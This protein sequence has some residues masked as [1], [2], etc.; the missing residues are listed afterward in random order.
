M[1]E[2]GRKLREL[3]MLCESFPSLLSKADCFESQENDINKRIHGENVRDENKEREKLE[4]C[5][6]HN[7]RLR[8]MRMKR[9]ASKRVEKRVVENCES[10]GERQR[11]SELNDCWENCCM[12]YTS[13]CV[14]NA[15]IL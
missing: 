11:E 12:K 6:N 1:S 14:D 9:M 13:A 7:R 4:I 15:K 5:V 8:Y 2:C 10:W 3:F